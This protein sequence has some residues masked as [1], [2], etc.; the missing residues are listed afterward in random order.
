MA[1]LILGSP[2]GVA[3][4][5]AAEAAGSD[6]PLPKVTIEAAREQ[7]LRRKVHQYVAAVVVR[8]WDE[9]LLRWNAPVCPLVAG[10]PKAFGEFILRR[11]S[12]AALNA[13]APLAGKVCRPNLYVVAT[14]E[15]DLFLKKWWA[16]NPRMYD[17]RHGLI[18]LRRFLESSRP[19]R[20]W[21][22]GALGCGD[23]APVPG[24][25]SLSIATVEGTGPS[26]AFAAAAPTCT[27][28]IDTHLSYADTESLSS[29]IIVIDLRKLKQT[30]IGQLADYIALVGLADVRLDAD[31]DAAPSILRLFAPHASAPPGLTVWDRALL[32]SLYNTRQQDKEQVSDMESTMV[33]RIA[34]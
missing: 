14:G 16:R 30:N 13:H 9:T 11:I 27:D 5:S 1:L 21:Y 22:N 23:G 2:P 18:P 31:P 6:T 7:G 19:V 33:G 20:V 28:G 32:Y 25:S 15:P 4:Q 17:R 29:A 26:S 8:P 24:G 34:P 3:G 12:R 10:L